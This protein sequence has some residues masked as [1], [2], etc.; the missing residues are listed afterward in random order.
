VIGTRTT[1]YRV[2]P[3]K[4]NCRQSIEREIDRRRSIKE[5]KGKKKRK[6]RKKEVEKKEYLARAPSSPACRHRPRVA[7]ASSSPAGRLRP[8]PLFLPLEETKRLPTWG[9]RSRR[10]NYHDK[11]FISLMFYH[12]Q[13]KYIC[14]DG[15]GAF[16][17]ELAKVCQLVI[18]KNHIA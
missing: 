6:R 11:P 12:L 7:Y 17:V 15:D 8:R 1:R 18:A 14:I 5:E 4:I 9:E 2:V 13:T 10:P 16:H 3:L